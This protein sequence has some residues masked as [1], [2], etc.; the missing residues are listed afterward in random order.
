MADDTEEFIREDESQ[1]L[2]KRIQFYDVITGIEKISAK[3][4]KWEDEQDF[5]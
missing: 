4:K 2:L 5:L 3:L 1:D